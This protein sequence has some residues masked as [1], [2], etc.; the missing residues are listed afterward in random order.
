MSVKLKNLSSVLLNSENLKPAKIEKPIISWKH[1]EKSVLKDE[2]LRI[3]REL[4]GLNE[5]PTI[6][7]KGYDIELENTIIMLDDEEHF[8]RYR[9]I[10][11][12]SDIYSQYTGFQVEKYRSYCRTYERDC[13]KSCSYGKEW[14]DLQ[15]V[16]EFGKAGE[17]GD[18]FYE[19]S[20]VWK[21]RAFQDFLVD[22]SSLIFKFSLVR[23]SVWDNLLINNKMYKINDILLTS[24]ADLRKALLKN[25]ER[26]IC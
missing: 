13:L 10:T 1:L 5:I 18:L 14:E 16:K 26:K 3:Y 11:L 4:G 2:V 6:Q 19:G 20:P 23:V 12:R 25:L 7:V 9:S 17:K 22:I 15:S 24:N 21:F 8:N